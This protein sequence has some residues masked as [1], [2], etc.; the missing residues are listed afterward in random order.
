MWASCDSSSRL[1]ACQIR[2]SSSSVESAPGSRKP[3]RRAVPRS[4]PQPTG[5]SSRPSRTDAAQAEQRGRCARAAGCPR[6]RRRT[7]GR[8]ARVTHRLRQVVEGDRLLRVERHRRASLAEHEHA[9]VDWLAPAVRPRVRCCLMSQNRS[10]RGVD[11][12]VLVRLSENV[13]VAPSRGFP[14]VGNMLFCHRTAVVADPGQSK[15]P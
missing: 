8:S 7:A 12:L 4:H 11:F 1:F 15:G 14:S 6:S 9:V 2:H 10:H 3:S 13:G 5:A